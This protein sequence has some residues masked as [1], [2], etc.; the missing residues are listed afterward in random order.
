MGNK[1]ILDDEIEVNLNF[2]DN[3]V[4]I[5]EPEE[6]E[7]KMTEEEAAFDPTLKK[8]KKKK[9]TPF[10]LDAAVAGN[11]QSETAEAKEDA[12]PAAAEEDIDLESFGKKKKKKKVTIEDDEE[13]G[14]EK[15]DGAVDDDIDLESFGKKKKKKK[16][17]ALNLEELDEALPKEDDDL[18]LESFGK[19]KEEEARRRGHGHQRRRGRKQ[20]ERGLRGVDGLGPRLLVRRA[21]AARVRHHARP[22]PRHGRR[23][24]EEVRHAAA[25][26][27]QGRHQEGRLR[28]LHG[29][30]QNAASSAQASAVLPHCRAGYPR[31]GH[32]RQ[33]PTHPQ[34]P[35]PAEAHRERPQAIH[36]GVCDMPHLPLARHHP[37]QGDPCVVPSVHDVSIEMLRADHQDWLPGR[38]REAVGEEGQAVSEKVPST[39]RLSSTLSHMSSAYER[40]VLYESCTLA[41]IKI[42]HP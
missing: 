17:E 27:R 32:R 1:Q 37:Q 22:Q 2:E 5:V 41:R 23:R 12:A 25:A 16:K 39:A 21:A 20:G 28:Q 11:D 14:G 7:L 3:C 4:E 34:G 26:G 9:K 31:R 38:H 6:A 10:D 35:L 30:R 18:D 42:L 36:Q 8:K 29:D 40:T 33:R 15:D 19:K 24:E 13:G